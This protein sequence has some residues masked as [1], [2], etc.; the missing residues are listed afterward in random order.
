MHTS[1]G[2]CSTEQKEPGLWTNWEGCLHNAQGSA[3]R[4]GPMLGPMTCLWLC[5]YGGF[6]RVSSL[7]PA[8]RGV[9]LGLSPQYN[10]SL[11]LALTLR[12][13]QG[14]PGVAPDL[15]EAAGSSQRTLC[16]PSHCNRLWRRLKCFPATCHAACLCFAGHMTQSG[17]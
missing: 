7:L 4:S 15:L 1:L 12:P 10:H 13:M 14:L 2:V 3:P 9:S 6:S 16:G 17:L 8:C 11:A 5:I